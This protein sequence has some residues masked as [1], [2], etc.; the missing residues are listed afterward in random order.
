MAMIR[1]VLEVVG[2]CECE[3]ERLFSLNAAIQNTLTE[4]ESAV[5]RFYVVA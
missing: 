5:M 3:R 1:H 2:R 4:N